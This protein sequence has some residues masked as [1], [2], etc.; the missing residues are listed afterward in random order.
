MKPELAYVI[1]FLQSDGH[2]S[3]VVGKG[4]LTIELSSKD[5]EILPKIGK[6]LTNSFSVRSR[7]RNTNF[8]DNYESTILTI[9][10]MDIRKLVFDLGVPEGRKSDLVE[11]PKEL[12]N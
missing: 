4:K 11:A 9:S 3:N 8:K 5:K 6:I 2:L 7:V 10:N 1:G 12:C